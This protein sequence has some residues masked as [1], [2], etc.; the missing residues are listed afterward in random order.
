MLYRTERWDG[1]AAPE[2]QYAFTVPNGSY[3]VRLHFA[4]NFSGAFGVGKRVFSVQVEGVTA[5]A[6]LDVYAA[7]GPNTALV[8][9]VTTT[10][11]DGQLNI[12]FLHGVEDPLINGIEVYSSP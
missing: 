4:E 7:A 9:S 1:N 11:S 6:N 10:V 3:E 12:L 8:R 5:L 2:L